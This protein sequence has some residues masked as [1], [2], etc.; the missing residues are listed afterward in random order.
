MYGLATSIGGGILVAVIIGLLTGLSGDGG[1]SYG[2][3]GFGV[4]IG[5]FL[6]I[7][8]FFFIS[9]RVTNK[10]QALFL[11]ANAEIQ[12]QKADRAIELL[13]EGYRWNRWAF[14]VKAQIDSQIG[15]ILYSLKKFGEAYKYLQNS[16]PR[17]Y[18]AYCLLVIGHLKN[19]RRKEALDAMELL[20]RFNKK[21]AFVFSLC[22]YLYEEE[23]DDHEQAIAVVK[24]GLKTLPKNQLLNEHLVALQNRNAFKMERYGEVWYQMFLDRKAVSRLQQKMIKDQQRRMKVSGVVR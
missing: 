8:A 19:N 18:L 5:L 23:L 13:K 14:L 9:R 2:W 6:A 20:M 3:W 1:L 10:L 7:V 16:N 12:K 24:R 4:F 11:R 17:L 21:E 15:V 22:A